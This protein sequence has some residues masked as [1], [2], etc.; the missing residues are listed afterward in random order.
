MP[1]GASV[2]MTAANQ[3][4]IRAWINNGAQNN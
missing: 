1:P 4:I 2:T 3:K